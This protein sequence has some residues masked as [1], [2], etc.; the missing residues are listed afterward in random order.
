MDSRRVSNCGFT[1]VNMYARFADKTNCKKDQCI[2]FG[3]GSGCNRC[4]N[5]RVKFFCMDQKPNEYT[6]CPY[7][8]GCRTRFSVRS[9]LGKF[10]ADVEKVDIMAN[11]LYEV[12]DVLEPTN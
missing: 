1:C 12:N 9:A 4:P 6:C 7:S 10:G 5:V 8:T 2:A 11:I 3:L